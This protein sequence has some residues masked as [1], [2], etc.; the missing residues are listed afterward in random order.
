MLHTDPELRKWHDWTDPDFFVTERHRESGLISLLLRQVL[1]ASVLRT[2]MTLT[3]WCLVAV[4]LGLG[5]AAFNTTSNILFLALSLLLS[6]LILS[7]VLSLINFKK[8]NWDLRSPSNLRAGEVCAAEIDLVNEKTVF[9]SMGI[10]FHLQSEIV[11]E[12]GK[13]Y[14]QNA[15][16]PGES[17]KLKWLITPQ[18]RGRF[19][20]RL[21]GV[22]SQFPF[23]FLQKTI[24]SDLHST[25]IVWPARLEYTFQIF[26]GGYRM[27]TGAVNKRL[28][29]GSD[30]L[31]IRP[32][33]RGDAPRFI[34]WKATARMG[35]LMI[36][37]LAHEGESGYKLYV[38]ADAAKWNEAQFERLCSLV[39]SLAEDLFYCGRLETAK[40]GDSAPLPMRSVKNLHTFF[41]ALSVLKRQEKPVDFPV[42][43][44]ANWLTFG[45]MG[46]RGVA[47]YLEGKHAGQIDD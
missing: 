28:G 38:D 5:A 35:R 27:S 36:R 9:P 14:V 29:Q 20:M 41:D 46:E 33:E 3:G 39:C 8:L 37:Q 45:L 17:C 31:N 40:L 43:Q 11:A 7:G 22:Q 32:Y 18:K 13:V 34:H 4:S 42:N 2:K 16:N 23:G 47:I 44:Q 21:S 25:V 10:C 6:S 12:E 30:L 26:S 24:G 15:L 19:G 1:P